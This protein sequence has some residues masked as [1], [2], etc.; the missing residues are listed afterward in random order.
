MTMTMLDNTAPWEERL[1]F[2]SSYQDDDDDDDDNDDGAGGGG[3]GG[4][5]GNT[6]DWILYCLF[7]KSTQQNLYITFY[8]HTSRQ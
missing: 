5:N 8:G 7:Y 2:R 4:V 1:L 3:D 6:D